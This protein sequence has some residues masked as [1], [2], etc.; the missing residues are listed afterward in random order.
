[1]TEQPAPVP[2][3]V[4]LAA[5]DDSEACHGVVRTAASLARGAGGA[6][7]HLVNV[8]EDLPPPIE[9]VPRPP[10]LGITLWEMET[11]A[12]R[13]LG[14]LAV[15]ARPHFTG[16]IV[17][18]LAAG[19]AWK[20]ILQVAADLQAD[21]IVVSTHGRSGL[22]RAVLGS[23]AETVV[24][25]ASCPVVVVRDKDYH[26]TLPPEIE[27]PC[28]DCLRVQGESGGGRLWCDRHSQHHPR[29]HVY[30][31]LPDEIFGAGSQVIRP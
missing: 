15:E 3:F 23:V 7:L 19:S 1:M 29:A 16:R 31:E 18:H 6:E 13:H 27:P 2:R 25:K 24:R 28:P 10:G 14:A 20:Q 4:L 5:V 22:K 11:A 30:H 17:T 12:S 21:V 9:V 8:L 26:A